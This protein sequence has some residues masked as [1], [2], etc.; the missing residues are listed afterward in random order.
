MRSSKLVKEDET[1]YVNII[2]DNSYWYQTRR[3]G[4]IVAQTHNE[5]EENR[6]ILNMDDK[7]I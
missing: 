6:T 7:R 4:E 3:E 2:M 1:S 5:K